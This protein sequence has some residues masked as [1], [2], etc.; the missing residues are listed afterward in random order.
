MSPAPLSLAEVVHPSLRGEPTEI[1]PRAIGL[2]PADAAELHLH[3]PSRA[4]TAL[5]SDDGG[6]LANAG[7]QRVVVRFAE[8]SGVERLRGPGMD[9]C[10]P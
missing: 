1:V 9:I 2:V 3:C 10:F 5:T 7:V 4:P 8:G 6:S